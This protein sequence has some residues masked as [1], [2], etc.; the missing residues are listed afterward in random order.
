MKRKATVLVTQA[1]APR[2]RQATNQ[3]IRATQRGVVVTPMRR[4]LMPAGLVAPRRTAGTE[5]KSVDIP[6]T[7]TNFGNAGA[8]AT[9]NLPV[10][11]AS[12]YNRIGRRIRMKSLHLRATIVLGGLNAAAI[13]SPTPGRVMV[14][15][16][17]QTNGA[18]PTAADLIA[19]Y[20]AAGV[21][22]N[23]PLDG[24]NMNNRDR[25]IVLMDDQLIFPPIGINGATPA[26]TALTFQAGNDTQGQGPQGQFNINRFI[27]LRGL[28][29]HFKA[30]AGNIGDIATGSLLLFT[31]SADGAANGA[32][33]LYWTSRLKFLD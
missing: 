14:V 24:L 32:Y 20:S 7:N 10:E 15:Y 18:V 13:T 33:Q 12:F 31:I 3:A 9:F 6:A 2:K 22:T 16:D 4:T 21:V 11:G 29:T 17:R 25:F 23:G 26:S 8:F 19:A 5:V 28:E 1:N 27:K 30:S